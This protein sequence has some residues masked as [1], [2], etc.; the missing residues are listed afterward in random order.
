M[1]GG[2]RIEDAGGYAKTS[3][4]LMKSKTH[5]KSYS[6]ANG[7]GELGKYEDT[8]EAIKSVQSA[9]EG[10]IKGHKMK[11]GYRY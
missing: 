2:T 6:S 5:L 8:T 3:D 4:A 11:D 9:G 1:A 10:K 7:A